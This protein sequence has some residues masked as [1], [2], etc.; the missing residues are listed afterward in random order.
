[1]ATAT[2]TITRTP[3]TVPLAESEAQ[4]TAAEKGA[5]AVVIGTAG[6]ATVGVFIW[7]AW[8][9]SQISIPI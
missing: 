6:M 4:F 1:M 7:A 2:P 3:Q 9:A 8:I 5:A